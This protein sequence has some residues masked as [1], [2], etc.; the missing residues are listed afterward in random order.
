M[1]NNRLRKAASISA[2]RGG[3]HRA[4]TRV[5]AEVLGLRKE[6]DPDKDRDCKAYVNLKYYRPDHQCFSDWKPKELEAFS[7]FCVKIARTDWTDIYRMGGKPGQKT[8][9]GYT[10]HRNL[11]VLPT[12]PE[13]DNL[14]KDLTWFELRIDRRVRVHGFR[15]INAFF[16]VFLDHDHEIYKG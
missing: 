9:M 3:T 2:D 15:I 11:S 8:G 1:S 7:Q 13:L 4:L 12:S 10:P 16:L 14:S 5:E 6:T